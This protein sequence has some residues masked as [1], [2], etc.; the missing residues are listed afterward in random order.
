[1][2]GTNA[3]FYIAGL[4]TLPALAA[5]GWLSLWAV[6]HWGRPLW[7]ATRALWTWGAFPGCQFC[8]TRHWSGHMRTVPH[9]QLAPRD[10]DIK[11]KPCA[12]K[13]QR[14]YERELGLQRHPVR[15]HHPYGAK[16]GWPHVRYEDKP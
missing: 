6:Y 7:W 16:P 3:L 4:V 5:V 11:C 13:H 8:G 1:M 15:T 14:S 12:T 10:W 2:T 9:M